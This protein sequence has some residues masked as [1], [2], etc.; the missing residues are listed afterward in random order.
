MATTQSPMARSEL[1]P[2]GATSDAW[3][4]Q[5]GVVVQHV[6]PGSPGAQA[7]LSEGDTLIR[8]GARPVRNYLDW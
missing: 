1:R 2:T 6:A 7:G 5:V 8:V 4:R 3:R